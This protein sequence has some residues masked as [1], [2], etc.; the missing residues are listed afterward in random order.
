MHYAQQ[1]ADPFIYYPG[2]RLNVSIITTIDGVDTT[3]ASMSPRPPEYA[4]WIAHVPVTLK[5]GDTVRVRVWASN[6]N[7]GIGNTRYITN[8]KAS[9]S[10]YTFSAEKVPVG[11]YVYASKNLGYGTMA[12]YFKTVLQKYGLTL[13]VD[14]NTNTVYTYTMK[15]VYDNL[16]NALD[17]THKLHQ[18][19]GQE[20]SFAF[21]SYGQSNNILLKDNT[22]DALYDRKG[23]FAIANK[24]LER[25]KDL[26]TIDLKATKNNRILYDSTDPNGAVNPSTNAVNIPLF[27][28]DEDD[29]SYTFRDGGT[30]QHVKLSTSTVQVR[31]GG[32][33][34]YNWH[35]AT[36]VAAQDFINNFYS[37][38]VTKMLV[39]A[40]VKEDYFYLKPEDLEKF[41][42]TIP[43]YLGQYGAYFYVNKIVDFTEGKLTKVQLI[44]L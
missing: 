6:C 31:V 43:I 5:A 36:A 27:T 34:T 7:V 23:T 32:S 24:T 25:T 44:K 42:P 1:N 20:L 15:K 28:Y 2:L 35:I 14:N 33:T 21:G 4:E 39:N 16:V 10:F 12:D 29:E 22:E 40:K 8:F 26:F 30:P 37:D 19:T 38:L 3:V 13:Y 41:D 17:W 11:G 9:L 18:H